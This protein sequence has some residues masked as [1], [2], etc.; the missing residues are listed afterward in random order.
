[1]VSSKVTRWV[2]KC[3]SSE[4]QKDLRKIQLT[5]GVV[6]AGYSFIIKNNSKKLIPSLLELS[7][8]LHPSYNIFTPRVQPKKKEK[9]RALSKQ[10]NKKQKGMEISTYQ[11]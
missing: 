3:I 2:I 5:A 7:T 10:T 8:F 11:R 1:M 6:E 9:H 4:Y